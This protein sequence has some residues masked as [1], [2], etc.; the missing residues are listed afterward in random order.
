[1]VKIYRISLLLFLALLSLSREIC[2]SGES[3]A[4]SY[5]RGVFC[6]L[7]GNMRAALNELNEAISEDSAFAKAYNAL[8]MV[9]IKLNQY[10]NAVT[11]LR[12]AIKLDSCYGLAYQNLGY[13]LYNK[14]ISN[15]IEAV[16]AWRKSLA[17]SS[18]SSSMAEAHY[19]IGQALFTMGKIDEAVK[20]YH[21][22]LAINRDGIQIRFALAQAYETKNE[23]QMAECAYRAII[24]DDSTF[25]PA[26][27][28]LG[29][30][31]YIKNDII[32]AIRFYSRAVE[33]ELPKCRSYRKLNDVLR[34]YLD[35]L[36]GARDSAFVVARF[37]DRYRSSILAGGRTR[38]ENKQELADALDDFE[39]SKTND[40][41]KIYE[42]FSDSFFVDG[43]ISGFFKEC[44]GDI[45]LDPRMAAPYYRLVKNQCALIMVIER[46]RNELKAKA[47]KTLP[48]CNLS[49]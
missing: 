6:Y 9:Y 22:A 34:V 41:K 2:F 29:D 27:N 37:L 25:T 18:D 28:A 8:G 30:L 20:E 23:L 19:N 35:D 15:E 49:P 48:G 39:K 24:N 42:I 1:M 12:Y 46:M 4:D 21:N 17:Y 13:A 45:R 16:G 40:I 11:A 10:D 33:C 47:E 43:I 38:F 32:N 7:N 5:R 31:Y 26:F 36:S 44:H 3:A 14:P